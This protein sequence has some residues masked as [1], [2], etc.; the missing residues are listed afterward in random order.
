MKRI[1]P[2]FSCI[3]MLCNAAAA[4]DARWTYGNH[5]LWGLSAYVTV[6]GESI[7][8][9]CLPD[10]GFEYPAA[11]LLLTP[12]LVRPHKNFKPNEA[13]E[14]YR[15][16]GDQSRGEGM[17]T[18]NSAGYYE[19]GGTTCEVNLEALQKGR[20]L[21]YFGAGGNVLEMSERAAESS[22]DVIARFPLAGS[23]AAIEQLIRAC[24][25]IRTDTIRHVTSA[26][27]D[28]V[29]SHRNA[30]RALRASDLTKPCA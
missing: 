2:V 20:A 9:R 21:L 5:P 13:V 30:A 4:Q 10:R 11:A 15:F 22:R 26:L 1:L 29:T 19:R 27:T 18:R 12:G 17:V 28:H 7:G 23:K 6:N 3:A 24:P 8:L 25:A 14:R 16:L